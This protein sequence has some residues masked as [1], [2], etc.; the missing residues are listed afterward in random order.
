[1][2]SNIFVFII[3]EVWSQ[4]CV[5]LFVLTGECFVYERKQNFAF[6]KNSYRLITCLFF[7]SI[8]IFFFVAGLSKA[9][10]S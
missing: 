8:K 9:K 7:L 5:I 6:C 3:A 1:M 2:F 10:M 4:G